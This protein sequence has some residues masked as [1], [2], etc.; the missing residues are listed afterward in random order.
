MESK[1]SGAQVPNPSAASE[2]AK[3]IQRE[4]K[5]K[6]AFK[7]LNDDFGTTIKKLVNKGGKVAKVSAVGCGYVVVVLMKLQC[8]TD[9]IPPPSTQTP[10]PV[11][12]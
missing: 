6:E 3:V 8:K 9:R 5:D 2:A 11:H 12:Q 7:K 4:E 10:I 1:D